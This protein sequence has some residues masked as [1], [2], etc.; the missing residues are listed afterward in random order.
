MGQFFGYFKFGLFPGIFQLFFMLSLPI[1]IWLFSVDSYSFGI[2]VFIFGAPFFRSLRN[3]FLKEQIKNE[4]NLKNLTKDE[5]L[6]FGQQLTHFE[7]EY[8]IRITIFPHLS[9]LT[10][11][12]DENGK[13]IE[14]EIT[15]RF[16]YLGFNN[17]YSFRSWINSP[18]IS[19]L[20]A[21]G[22]PSLL[23]TT[24]PQTWGNLISNQFKE[25]GKIDLTKLPKIPLVTGN[26]F[27][28]ADSDL[29]FYIAGNQNEEE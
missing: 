19:R 23:Y 29:N 6:S 20:L 14:D 27:L 17:D 21:D 13:L 1:A 12:L 7:N 5:N 25:E 15:S 9:E 8:P 3:K 24:S 18:A 26:K 16:F 2:L 28:V 22:V 10:D 4:L 11:H